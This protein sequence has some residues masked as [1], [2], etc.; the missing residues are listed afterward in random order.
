M[1][2]VTGMRIEK[3]GGRERSRSKK[4][5]TCTVRDRVG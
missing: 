3:C 1:H 2:T 4:A 5:C